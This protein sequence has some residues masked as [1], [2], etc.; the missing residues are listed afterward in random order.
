MKSFIIIFLMLLTS[1]NPYYKFIKANKFSR[2]IILIDNPI[3]Y[4]VEDV[5]LLTR[6]NKY[7]FKR[8][9]TLNLIGFY[10]NLK[11]SLG[12]VFCVFQNDTIAIKSPEA[13]TLKEYRKQFLNYIPKKLVTNADYYN[14]M[15]ESDVIYYSVYGQNE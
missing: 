10:P 1:C 12:V 3:V 14:T 7:N 5:K 13:T 2:A 4:N 15:I 11:D 9:D 6:N 8:F